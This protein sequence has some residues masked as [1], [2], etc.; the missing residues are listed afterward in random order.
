MLLTAPLIRLLYFKNEKA[1]SLH[2]GIYHLTEL[3]AGL[4][5]L[6]HMQRFPSGQLYAIKPCDPS[7]NILPPAH[8]GI[9]LRPEDVNSA[10]P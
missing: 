6:R 3:A 9:G 4:R 7:L 10:R 2:A 5:A 1:R 8:F